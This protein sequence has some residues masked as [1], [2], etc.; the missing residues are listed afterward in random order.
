M[1]GRLWYPQLDVYDC[2]RR[3]SALISAYPTAPGVERLCIAD[4]YLANPPLL[5]WSKMNK[6]VRQ[7][8]TA[9]AI[10]RPQQSFLTYPAPSL[11]FGKME[12]VQKEALRAMGG[13]GLISIKQFQRGVAEFTEF[14]HNTFIRVLAGK[15][16]SGEKDLVRFLTKEFAVNSEPGSVGLRTSTGLRRAV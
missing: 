6:E 16:A 8:F 5:H 12:P 14:G 1:T 7:A 15:V 9:L 2:V 4:F 10:A 13:K 11:L 3:L